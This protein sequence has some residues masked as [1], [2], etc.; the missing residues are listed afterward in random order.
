MLTELEDRALTLTSKKPNAIP[1]W[2]ATSQRCCGIPRRIPPP[3]AAA[4]PCWRSI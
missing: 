2:G 4:R 1:P 3:P